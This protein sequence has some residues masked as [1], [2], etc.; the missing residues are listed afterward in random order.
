MTTSRSVENA[1]CQEQ[2]LSRS[3]ATE[4]FNLVDKQEYDITVLKIEA[5]YQDS[6]HTLELDRLELFYVE[7]EK[8]LKAEKRRQFLYSILVTTVAGVSVWVGATAV[9]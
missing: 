2:G 5:A 6:F 1:Y 3:E 7:R 9:K 4:L 8:E